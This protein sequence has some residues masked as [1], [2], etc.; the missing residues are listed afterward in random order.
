MTP[1]YFG[2]THMFPWRIS[3][4]NIVYI[5]IYIYIYIY[6]VEFTVFN[7]KK[8]E[9][10]LTVLVPALLYMILIYICC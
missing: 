2:E 8:V 10:Y 3:V 7:I 4:Y 1:R 6:W 9:Q 5:Y